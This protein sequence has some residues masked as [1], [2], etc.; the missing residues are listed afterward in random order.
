MKIEKLRE[1]I[2]KKVAI[3]GYWKEG[4][5]VKNFLKKL[6]I[7]NIFILD[8]NDILEREEWIFYE[9]WEKYLENIENFDLIIKTPWI[10]PYINNLTQFNDK[11]TSSV[12]IFLNNYIW[13]VIGLTWTKWKSTTSTLLYLS[14]QNA[15]YNVKLV[16]NIWSPVL[17]EIDIL[18]NEKYDYVIFEMSSYMLEWLS[19]QLYIWYLNNLFIC[20]YDWHFWAIN[21]NN[22]KKNILDIAKNKIANIQTIKKLWKLDNVKYF[23]ENTNIFYKD[24]KFYI[25]NEVVLED[26]NF[27]LKWD[28][29]RI[30]IC[31]ILAILN[32][33]NIDKVSSKWISF[34]L[35][36]WLKEALEN[37]NWLP[38]RIQDIWTY[39]QITFIDDAIATTP[40]S[41]KAAINTFWDKIWTL[42]L[43]WQDSWFDFQELVN[44]IL[45]SNIK[46]LVLFP[47]T[48]L[49]IFWDLSK[50]D[51]E[52]NFVLEINW[53]KFNVFKTKSMENAVKF[54]Y[55]FTE[56]WK[57]CLLSTASPSFSVWTSYI[58]KWTRFQEFVKKYSK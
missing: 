31:W 45:N 37:F 17:D 44:I 47:D 33:I 41:T 32:Q 53:K 54:A 52:T 35:I 46:N 21:Y 29:N 18:S 57:I 5:S 25:D 3:L 6:D 11:I 1:F 48:W 23:W 2:D 24:K 39:K 10:S 26:K 40:D 8:K 22:A 4:K 51:F 15:W 28:H 16:W 9:T 56:V 12:E 38:H 36:N 55:D 50:Y 14:L 34:R 13:K 19:W 49:K 27:L 42:F 7:K 58:E 20:H 43:W 30:N